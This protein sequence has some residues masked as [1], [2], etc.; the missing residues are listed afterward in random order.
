MGEISERW[1]TTWV[2]ST[3]NIDHIVTDEENV[4]GGRT[5]Y[6]TRRAICGVEFHTGS[7]ET[8]PGW[9][10]QECFD[11]CR[12]HTRAYLAEKLRDIPQGR[13]RVSPWRR[14]IDCLLYRR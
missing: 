13:K 8:P 4:I 3:D 2:T 10:C 5:Y 12:A 14:L 9:T 6:G 1:L 11:I 7:M